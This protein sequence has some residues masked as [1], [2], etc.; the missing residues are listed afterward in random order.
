MT[1]E[2]IDE[3][4]PAGDDEL[5]LSQTLTL[6]VEY[7]LEQHPFKGMPRFVRL[8]GAGLGCLELFYHEGRFYAARNNSVDIDLIELGDDLKSAYCEL[9]S[10]LYRGRKPDNFAESLAQAILEI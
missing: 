1:Y 5:E 3:Y 8:L 10:R 9:I 2:Q 7:T 4:R 6:A